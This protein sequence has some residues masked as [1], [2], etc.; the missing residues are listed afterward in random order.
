MAVDYS[1]KIPVSGDAAMALAKSILGPYGQY[2]SDE[3]YALRGLSAGDVIS[4]LSESARPFREIEQQNIERARIAQQIAAYAQQ[5][6]ARENAARIEALARIEAQG[7][8]GN[9]QRDV[10]GIQGQSMRDVQGGKIRQAQEMTKWR[11]DPRAQRP[12]QVS[13]Q[14]DQVMIQQY[15]TDFLKKAKEAG[16]EL[17]PAQA[18]EMAHRR[19]FEEKN[20]GVGGGIKGLSD[21]FA[22]YPGF[23]ENAGESG[24]NDPNRLSGP[25]RRQVTGS[26]GPGLSMA[27][28][29]MNAD[30]ATNPLGPPVNGPIFGRPENYHSG[31]ADYGVAPT[32]VPNGLGFAPL[33]TKRVN[34]WE[35]HPDSTAGQSGYFQPVASRTESIIK[36]GQDRTLQEETNA[37][38]EAK[39]NPAYMNAV[40]PVPQR[41][42][43]APTLSDMT[44]WFAKRYRETGGNTDYEPSTGGA[45]VAKWMLRKLLNRLPQPSDEAVATM[46][47]AWP[48]I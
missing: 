20:R 46:S 7:L 24:L 21:D 2:D 38:R 25:M 43:P 15:R 8:S 29:E 19:L 22:P 6:R 5:S 35:V 34:K 11:T 37:W 13:P 36:A 10:A 42:L 41:R 9:A 28:T 23:V 32:T 45:R 3:A 30:A 17:S 12:V 47:N 1:G 39:H 4:A 48:G 33:P 14:V 27:M 18:T 26:L 40:A 16:Q 44:E 31:A